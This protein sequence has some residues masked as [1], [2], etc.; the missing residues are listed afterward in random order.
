MVYASCA[1]AKERTEGVPRVRHHIS[2]HIN[3]GLIPV[4]KNIFIYEEPCFMLLSRG[5]S[6]Y[7]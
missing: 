7:F 4:S 2:Y 1:V 6:C 3:L 5:C